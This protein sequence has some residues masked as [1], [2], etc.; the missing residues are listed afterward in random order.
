MLVERFT[1]PTVRVE[2][3]DGTMFVIFDEKDDMTLVNIRLVI[4]KAGSNL[5]AWTETVSRLLAIALS[6]GATLD[7]ILTEISTQTS[8]RMVYN[9]NVPIRS[10]PE[11][12][13][14][15]IQKYRWDKMERIEERTKLP[16]DRRRR[17]ARFENVER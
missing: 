9:R 17:P 7:E 14:Y 2:T 15:A 13:A 4:G 3:P 11:G 16:M 5:T 8:D 1:S 10:G 6:R 12:L